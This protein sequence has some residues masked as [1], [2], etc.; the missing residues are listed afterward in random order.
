MRDPNWCPRCG[1]WN[2]CIAEDIEQFENKLNNLRSDIKDMLQKKV[3]EQSTDPRFM[4]TPF[5]S[6][7]SS[8]KIGEKS[9]VD[10]VV[11]KI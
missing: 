8:S 4:I 5:L 2:E 11:D 10:W 3:H 1:T 7:Q 9:K 6:K